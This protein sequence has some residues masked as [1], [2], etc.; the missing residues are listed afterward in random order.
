MS[1]GDQET[2]GEDT[3]DDDQLGSYG[4]CSNVATHYCLKAVRR[5]EGFELEVADPK[6]K[7]REGKAGK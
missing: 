1:S 6:D 7:V 2:K 4:D 3:G 5:D